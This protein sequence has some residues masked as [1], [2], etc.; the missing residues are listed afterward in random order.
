[1]YL[2]LRGSQGAVLRAAAESILPKDDYQLFEAALAVISRA[3]AERDKIAHGL[4][5]FCDD[6]PDD[7]ILLSSRYAL[8]GYANSVEQW[9]TKNFTK[10]HRTVKSLAILTP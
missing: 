7:L 6:L 10:P 8:I 9:T 4:W 2:S 5:G 1:M 3:K